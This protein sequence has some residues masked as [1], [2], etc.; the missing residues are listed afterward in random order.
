VLPVK[1][2]N[3]DPASADAGDVGR[4]ISSVNG[5]HLLPGPTGERLSLVW[6]LS[7]IMID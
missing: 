6:V 2:A 4:L 3:P 1:K 5:Y 7:I